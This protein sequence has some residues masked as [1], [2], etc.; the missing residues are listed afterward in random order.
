MNEKGTLK[1]YIYFILS[2]YIPF[3]DHMQF[4]KLWPTLYSRGNMSERLW[5]V[6]KIGT[7]DLI[8][9]L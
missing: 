9:L 3:I 8:K 1:T 7:H 2:Q 5:R 4:S 6:N